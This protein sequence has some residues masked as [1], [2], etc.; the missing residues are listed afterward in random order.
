MYRVKKKLKKIRKIYKHIS[1]EGRQRKCRCAAIHLFEETLTYAEF[2]SE[3]GPRI[4]TNNVIKRLNREIRSCTRV[5]GCFL[6]GNSAL[7]LG[8]ARLRHVAD[9]SIAG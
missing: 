9:T 6:D 4:R 8:C 7:M 2:P 1:A 5:V 3:H